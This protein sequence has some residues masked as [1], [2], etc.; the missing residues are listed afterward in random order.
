MIAFLQIIFVITEI[1]PSLFMLIVDL[2]NLLSPIVK[3][4]IARCRF[5]TG[6]R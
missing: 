6:S 1:F 4:N 3:N 2:L 5:F